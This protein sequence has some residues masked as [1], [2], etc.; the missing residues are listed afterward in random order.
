MNPSQYLFGMGDGIKNYYSVIYHVVHGEGWHFKG[1]LHP[2]GDSITFADGQPILTFIFKL[3]FDPTVQNGTALLGAMN[4]IMILGLVVTAW[5]IHIILK[6]ALVPAWFAVPFAIIIAFLSPQLQRFTGHYALAYT[7]FIPL[8]WL[9]VIKVY[10]CDRKWI[11][12]M[13]SIL[14]VILFSLNQPYYLLIS[15]SLLGSILIYDI[16]SIW[17]FNGSRE[18]W[19]WLT[20]MTIL[21][22]IAIMAFFSV[23]DQCSDRPTTP[24]GVSAYVSSFSGVF[25]PVHGPMFT[26]VRDYLFRLWRYPGWEG[27]GYVGIPASL[28]MVFFVLNFLKS[29]Y[30]RKWNT[31]FWRASPKVIQVA[32]IPSI[33]VFLVSAGVLNRIGLLWLSDHIEGL[34]QFRS[35]GRL[36]W[37]FYYVFTVSAVF[38]FYSIY[39]YI[40]FKS[41]G[42]LKSTAITMMVLIAG[43]WTIDMV[44]NIKGNKSLMIK[45]APHKHSFNSGFADILKISGHSAADF[46]AI[47][48]LPFTLLGS[49]KIGLNEGRWSMAHCMNASFSTGLPMLGGSMSRTSVKVTEMQ[50]GL[51]GAPILNRPILDDLQSEKPLLMIWSYE[52]LAKGEEFMLS[53]GKE[54]YSCDGFAMYTL[55]PKDIKQAVEKRKIETTHNIGYPAIKADL[56]AFFQNTINIEEGFL[57]KDTIIVANDSSQFANVSYWVKMNHRGMGLVDIRVKRLTS[58]DEFE[59]TLIRVGGS[60]DFINGWLRVEGEVPLS[61]GENHLRIDVISA[62]GLI[63]HLEIRTG[64]SEEMTNRGIWNNYPILS[65]Q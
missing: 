53:Q 43:V 21:P 15:L 30:K 13:V 44:S 16:I 23:T 12:S 22:M 55:D 9:L 48:P 39:R 40:K 24:Y 3:L 32:F 37:I 46:E 2:Y 8:I 47:L 61:I 58:D 26:L 50:A 27:L 1:M 28:F 6:K 20:F 60:C 33:F 56:N 10:E 54:I 42:K 31:F 57:L 52:P 29:L 19:V 4:L 41:S 45:D 65:K 18:N 25:I 51:V 59:Q 49:E 34:K 17:A 35:L 63:S 64:D 11:W 62:T 7:F 36:V 14:V 38:Y 5:L